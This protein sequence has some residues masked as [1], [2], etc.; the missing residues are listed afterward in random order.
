MI[1]F[2]QPAEASD[3]LDLGIAISLI[4]WLDDPAQPPMNSLMMI[5]LTVLLQDIFKLLDRREDQM[6]EAFSFY[7]FDKPFGV[8]I[9][10]RLW[11]GSF[12]DSMPAF[13]RISENPS[14]LYSGSRSWIRYFLPWRNPSWQSVRARA[15]CF[16]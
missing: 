5:I 10:I 4:L 3:A 14:V 7:G 11:A 8:G 1:R 6:V 15:T 12:T 16:M 13:L 2:E 9:Q